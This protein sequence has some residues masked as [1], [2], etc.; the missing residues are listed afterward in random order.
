ML[1]A[2]MAK[3]FSIM[4]NKTKNGQRLHNL[5]Q[6]PPAIRI[7]ELQE[8]IYRHRLQDKNQTIVTI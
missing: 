7:L 5:P 4:K 6:L 8:L 1:N 3:L 2:S